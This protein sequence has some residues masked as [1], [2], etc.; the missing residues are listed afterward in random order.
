[1]NIKGQSGGFIYIL[2]RSDGNGMRLTPQQIQI[3]TDVVTRL[4]GATAEAYLYGS[5]LNEQ[6]RGGDIDILI[7]TDRRVSRIAQGR[8]Q[9]ELENR[10]G[11]PVDLLI[12]VRSEKPT[13]FQVIARLQ[14]AR[15]ETPQ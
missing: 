9:M 2:C 7:E 6:A 8:I 11:L 12:H 14:A 4:V 10:L 13:P 3:I 1:L 5:R 15:L